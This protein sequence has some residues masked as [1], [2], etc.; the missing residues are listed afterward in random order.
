MAFCC[1][2]V[3]IWFEFRNLSV[4]RGLNLLAESAFEKLK[5]LAVTGGIPRYLEEIQPQ[6]TAY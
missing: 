6:Q 2:G 3:I 1:F 5:I 4:L